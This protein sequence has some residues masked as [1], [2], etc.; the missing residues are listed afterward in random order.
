L[1]PLFLQQPHA[2]SLINAA[3]GVALGSF[4]GRT[5]TVT[6]RMFMAAAEEVRP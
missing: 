4:L 5:G 2:P 6:D 3:T 1:I